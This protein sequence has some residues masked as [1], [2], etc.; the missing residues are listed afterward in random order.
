MAQG[1]LREGLDPM[2]GVFYLADS[3][4]NVD[5]G[6]EWWTQ[7]EAVVG[8]L[9]AY[10]ETGRQDFLE[11]A[12]DTW[13]FIKGHMLDHRHGEWHRR[14]DREGTP[15]PGHEI[16]GPWKCPYHNARACLEVMRRSQ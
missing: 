16:V 2:G 10:Q 7:A 5:K 15:E 13:G 6:K 14:V 8:F 4:G 9:N 11:A 12:W 1:V 3:A